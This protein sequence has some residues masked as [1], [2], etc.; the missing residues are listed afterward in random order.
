[1]NQHSKLSWIVT[2]IIIFL[3]LADALGTATVPIN[4]PEVKCFYTVAQ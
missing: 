2:L 4:Q 3:I 1:M